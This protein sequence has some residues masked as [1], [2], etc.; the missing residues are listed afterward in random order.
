MRSEVEK[1]LDKSFAI[2]PMN[3]KHTALKSIQKVEAIGLS[4]TESN[5]EV[6]T[7]LEIL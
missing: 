7:I 3:V 2:Y 6:L 4:G 1:V 5:R